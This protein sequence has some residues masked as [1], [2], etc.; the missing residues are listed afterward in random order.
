M[1]V[2]FN[3]R[4]RVIVVEGGYI[5]RPSAYGVFSKVMFTLSFPFKEKIDRVGA[6]TT[7]FGDKLRL[8][9]VKHYQ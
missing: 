3:Q 9:T 4:E 1:N 8:E 5:K 2:L 7:K 6:T